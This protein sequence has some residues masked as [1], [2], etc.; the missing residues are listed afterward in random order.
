MDSIR[1]NERRT[2]PPRCHVYKSATLL[3]TE[4]FVSAL[5]NPPPHCLYTRIVCKVITIARTETGRV[6]FFSHVFLTFMRVQRSGEKNRGA[7]TFFFY[8][9]PRRTRVALNFQLRNEGWKGNERM[10][11]TESRRFVS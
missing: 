10:K 2:H 7:R 4:S 6:F 5:L 3:E 8:F 1:E 11:R 9:H